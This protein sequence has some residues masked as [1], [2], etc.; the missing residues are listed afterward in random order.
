MGFGF[1]AVAAAF[2]AFKEPPI[3]LAGNGLTKWMLVNTS[4][5]F[6]KLTI[7]E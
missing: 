1:A 3:Q 7:K 6:K 2:N 5:N 4:V